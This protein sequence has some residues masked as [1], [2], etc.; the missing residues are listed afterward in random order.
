MTMNGD[1]LFDRFEIISIRSLQRNQ[2]INQPFPGFSIN[3]KGDKNY[4]W[5]VD[6]VQ[7]DGNPDGIAMLI[8]IGQE[9]TQYK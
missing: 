3:S 1:I 2:E 6:D 4:P 7:E 8:D 5:I 9:E